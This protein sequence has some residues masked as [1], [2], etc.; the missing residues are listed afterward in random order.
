MSEEAKQAR[1]DYIKNWR[2]NN[3]GRVKQYNKDYWERKAKEIKN[4]K[5][6]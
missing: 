4:K 3:P 2:K 6:E 5:T 1:K